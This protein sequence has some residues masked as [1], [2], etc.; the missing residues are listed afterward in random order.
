MESEELA[1]MKEKY[2]DMKNGI[3]KTSV[4]FN[5]FSQ[6]IREK[7]HIGNLMEGTVRSSIAQFH[8]CV[9]RELN[10]KRIVKSYYIADGEMTSSG[11]VFKSHH[12]QDYD[13]ILSEIRALSELSHPNIVRLYEVYMSEKYIHLVI[14]H[15]KGGELFDTLSYDRLN[16]SQSLS[17]LIQLLEAIK[18]MHEK[19]FAHRGLCIENILFVG[20]DK[21]RIKLIGLSGAAKSPF[22]YRSRYGSP[23]YMAPEVFQQEYDEKCDIWSI[24]VIFFTMICGHQPFQ[25]NSFSELMKKVIKI[26]YISS[27][28]WKNLDKEVKKFIK[29]IL[30]T[31]NR[32]TA[33]KILKFPLIQKYLNENNKQVIKRLIKSVKSIRNEFGFSQKVKLGNKLKIA[34]YKIL[35]PLNLLH[36][37]I[38]LETLWLELDSNG[39]DVI[40][41]S[42][43]VQNIETLLSKPELSEKAFNMLKKFDLD[44]RG[45]VSKDEFIGL[46]VEINDKSLIRQAFNTIDQDSDGL[47]DSTDFDTYFKASDYDGLKELIQECLEKSK[48]DF[49]TFYV[50]VTKF[51][52]SF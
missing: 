41:E 48:L 7:Y 42:D 22:G 10:L 47:I 9:H 23:M 44:S 4:I 21:K 2:R 43:L 8:F 13:L 26:D 16:L 34:V 3:S 40:M 20:N 38:T 45:C 5:D 27:P 12:T 30:V 35:S 51:V 39:L 36:D 49:E 28:N 1:F 32:P 33:D 29:K 11:I 6:D 25:S 37:L 17:I 52:V 15:L 24:G 14:E 18:F 46:L 19:G 31:K 50:L